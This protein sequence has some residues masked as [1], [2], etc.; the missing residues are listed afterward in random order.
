MS[1]P[2]STTTGPTQLAPR[3]T[4][5][6]DSFFLFTNTIASAN[7][8][9]R[10]TCECSA[11]AYDNTAQ[12]HHADHIDPTARQTSARAHSNCPPVQGSRG[13][14]VDVDPDEPIT[15]SSSPIRPCA[16]N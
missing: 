13:L 12:L 8:T 16:G 15:N 1:S 14:S 9:T 11:S 5:T 3:C 7:G 2:A 10:N 4:G 6:S